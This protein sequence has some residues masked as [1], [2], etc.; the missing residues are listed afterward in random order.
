MQFRLLSCPPPK[1]HFQTGG[2]RIGPTLAN[3]RA[4]QPLQIVSSWRL[5][6]FFS[7]C[8]RLL[9]QYRCGQKL[10]LLYQSPVERDEERDLTFSFMPRR[11]TK[12]EYRNSWSCYEHP[13]VTGRNV[14]VKLQRDKKVGRRMVWTG[15]LTLL[16]HMLRR[17]HYLKLPNK[18]LHFVTQIH[19]EYSTYPKNL[20]Y[21]HERIYHEEMVQI[22][23][24]FKLDLGKQYKVC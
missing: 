5:N 22:I 10:L 21:S 18:I 13:T 9:N 7:Q 8:S 3:F 12:I 17:L 2:E 14:Q 16:T 4:V 11:A 15:I 24:S 23:S 6:P 1:S 20:T 19:N